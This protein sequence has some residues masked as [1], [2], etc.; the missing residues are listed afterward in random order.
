MNRRAFLMRAGEAL[1]G[2][3][4]LAVAWPG[5]ARSGGRASNVFEGRDVF[6]RLVRLAM[7][8][9]W[10]DRPIG[11]R[12]GAIG[13]ALRQTPYASGTLERYEDREVCSVDLRGLD[14]VTFYEIALGFARM[15]R[16]V[17]RT[18]EALL[19]EIAF[20]RYRGGRL[21][22]YASRLHYTSD[23]L[24]DNDAKRVVRV[25]THELPGA[26]RFTKRV[27]FMSRHPGAYLQL[28]NNPALVEKIARTEADINAR[29]TRYLPKEKVRAAQP[30]LKTGDIVGVTTALDGLDCAHTG[31]CYRD[32]RGVLRFLHASTT[33]KEVVLDHE[34]ATYLA[35]VTTHTGI[36]VARP[37]D[38]A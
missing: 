11:E 17:E 37:L 16:R 34:L 2:A 13:M 20:M 36:M 32:E 26:I 25:V 31:L 24:A 23:W 29:P 28:R 8:E 27:D 33:R 15:L 21:T 10:S 30:L 22:D 5:R 4:T 3:G 18:P 1:L 14:C 19:S 38:V 6:D 7:T 12:M 35:S 9:A